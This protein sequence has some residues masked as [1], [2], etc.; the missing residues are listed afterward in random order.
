[1]HRRRSSTNGSI[2]SCSLQ[3][4]PRG[5]RR[6]GVAV[7][8][9]PSARTERV[10]VERE[11]RLFDG[12]GDVLGGHAR[13]HRLRHR[14]GVDRELGVAHE[15][16]AQELR[17]REIAGSRGKSPEVSSPTGRAPLRICRSG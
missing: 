1:M 5:F 11:N 2:A 8:V 17:G 10:D 4:F 14:R 16:S 13:D 3:Q 9:L 15:K 7:R 6:L 12:G